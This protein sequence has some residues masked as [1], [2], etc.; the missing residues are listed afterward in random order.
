MGQTRS[1]RGRNVRTRLR[2]SLRWHR[3]G[4]RGGEP[5][6]AFAIERRLWARKARLRGS[7]REGPE[8]APIEASKAVVC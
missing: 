5:Y 6:F 1:P 3:E 2:P 4:R 7:P 8:S